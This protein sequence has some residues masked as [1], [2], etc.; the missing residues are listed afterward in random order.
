MI[1]T[2]LVRRLGVTVT[3]TA[4]EAGLI[5]AGENT[6]LA[7]S[8]TGGGCPGPGFPDCGPR[9]GGSTGLD[10]NLF[11]L[12]NIHL[13]TNLSRAVLARSHDDL[14]EQSA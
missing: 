8:S 7:D 11:H 13:S 5:L 14:P 9:T 3:A 2:L 6:A 10:L 1:P 4:L 12:L